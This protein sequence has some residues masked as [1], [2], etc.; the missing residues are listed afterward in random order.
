MWLFYLAGLLVVL[1]IVGLFAGAG[2]FSLILIPLAIIAALTGLWAAAA[3]RAGGD[4]AAHRRGRRQTAPSG[5]DLP[6]SF[7]NG[8]A[9]A[10]T[11]PDALVEQRL[12]QQ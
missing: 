10:P 11:T 4:R 6:H 12:E 3:H 9:S 7:G 2:V 1:A 8:S 5:S